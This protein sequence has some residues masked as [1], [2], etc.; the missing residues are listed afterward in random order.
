M[1]ISYLVTVKD[2]LE[3]IKKLIPYLLSKKDEEDEIVVLQDIE[4]P[5]KENEIYR[6]LKEI[7][8]LSKIFSSGDLFYNN[9]SLNNDFASFKNYG[10]KQCGGD[11]IF[12]VDADEIPSS[13]LLENLKSILLENDEIDLFWVPRINIVKGLTDEWARKWYWNVSHC[14]DYKDPL[15]NWPDYQSRIFKNKKN[16]NWN[17]KVHER[18][19]GHETETRLPAQSEFCLYHEKSLEKQILQNEHYSKIIQNE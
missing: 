4:N 15:I 2:E 17:N 3:E 14:F 11:I 19:F 10:K 6:Y 1:N 7:D 13:Y 12:Q 8:L 16:I 18:I 5:D 9:Y